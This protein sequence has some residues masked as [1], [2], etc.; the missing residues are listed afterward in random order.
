MHTCSDCGYQTDNPRTYANHR[1]WKH[2]TAKQKERANSNLKKACQERATKYTYESVTRTCDHC[3]AEY[4]TRQR[5]LTETMELLNWRYKSAPHENAYCCVRCR[6]LAGVGNRPPVEEVWTR[7]KRELASEKTK[8]LWKDPGYAKKVLSQNRRF[9]SKRERE[10]RKYFQNNYPVDKWTCGKVG[11]L[12]GR[13]LTCDMVSHSLKTIVEYDGIWHFVDIHGQLEQKQSQDRALETW[14][15]LNGYRLI[16][17]DEDS[18]L[19]DKDIE[20][21]VYYDQRSILKIGTRYEQE[22]QATSH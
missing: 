4:Q 14:A 11:E 21:Y 18:K 8:Q 1:R 13:T 16:R 20:H 22:G 10:I 2:S 19:S 9:S 3:G 17:V 7:E 15:L 5:Y 6:N 12:E